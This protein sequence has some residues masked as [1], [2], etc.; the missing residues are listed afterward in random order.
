[1]GQATMEVERYGRRA[2]KKL[3]ADTDRVDGKSKRK[4]RAGGS[5]VGCLCRGVRTAPPACGVATLSDPQLV[6]TT[7]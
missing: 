2:D 6:S 4:G 5:R 1:M 3:D 7:I